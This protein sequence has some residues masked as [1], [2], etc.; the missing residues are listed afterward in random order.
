MYIVTV[1][2]TINTVPTVDSMPLRFRGAWSG[3][4]IRNFPCHF[5]LLSNALKVLYIIALEL[6]LYTVQGYVFKSKSTH[7]GDWRGKLPFVEEFSATL[8]AVPGALLL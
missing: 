3:K 1:I 6:E 8:E 5:Y 4:H 7:G 2:V